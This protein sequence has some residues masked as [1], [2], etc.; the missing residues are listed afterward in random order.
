MQPLHPLSSGT[1]RT[2]YWAAEWGHRIGYRAAEWGH[3]P[4][5]DRASTGDH[6]LGGIEI[7]Q[8][9]EDAV[10]DALRGDTSSLSRHWARRLT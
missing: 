6:G 2:G 3:R 8:A 7:A 9:R 1:H 10:A 5:Q 4:R